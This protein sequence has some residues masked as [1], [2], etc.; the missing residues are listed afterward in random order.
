MGDRFEGEAAGAR[1][2]A[3]DRRYD[4]VEY[5]QRGHDNQHPV[6]GHEY[7]GCYGIQYRVSVGSSNRRGHTDQFADAYVGRRKRYSALPAQITAGMTIRDTTNP[8]AI[9][10]GTTVLSNS[11][12]GNSVTMSNSATGSGVAS[13]DLI[14]FGT[15][16]PAGTG[17]WPWWGTGTTISSVTLPTTAVMSASPNSSPTGPGILKGD[18][19]IAAP[20]YQIVGFANDYRTSDTASL[21]TSSN[22]VKITGS[23]CLKTPGGLG[24]YYADAITAAQNALVAEQA[25]RV[26]AGGQGGT[27]VIAGGTRLLA[28][29]FVMGIGAPAHKFIAERQLR[30]HLGFLAGTG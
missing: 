17:S 25:A 28:P 24:T 18:N 23:G 5:R 6:L 7:D 19:I 2:E 3:A 21:N 26:A 30:R 10:S 14:T 20:L 16:I 8:S 22:I 11:T 27:N 13:N 15:S 9:P 12:G 4:G 1:T 29:I